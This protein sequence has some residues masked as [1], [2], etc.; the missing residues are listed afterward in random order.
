MEQLTSTLYRNIDSSSDE[1]IVGRQYVLAC[2]ANHCV[3]LE[4]DFV[5]CGAYTG[6]GIKT[7]VDYLGGPAF[8]KT[9]WGMLS[10]FAC[11]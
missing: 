1:G 9:F 10:P 7:V 11:W 5:E 8:A 3:Q 6:V 2:A 4:G